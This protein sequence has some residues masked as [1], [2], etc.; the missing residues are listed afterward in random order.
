MGTNRTTCSIIAVY[1]FYGF[2]WSVSWC[3]GKCSTPAFHLASSEPWMLGCGHSGIEMCFRIFLPEK[4]IRFF[5]VAPPQRAKSLIW[6][7]VSVSVSRWLVAALIVTT[8]ENF[9]NC[10]KSSKI[11]FWATLPGSP[12]WVNTKFGLI[13]IWT[14]KFFPL[15]L[16][17]IFFFKFLIARLLL[18]EH[19]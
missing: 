7:L 18:A 11:P 14:K 5:S 1:L 13:Q 10:I 8:Y 16:C 3:A 4:V 12:Q 6:S 15:N 19:Y 2:S 17:S 9:E